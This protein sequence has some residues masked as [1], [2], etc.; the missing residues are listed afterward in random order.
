MT[1]KE[2]LELLK[3]IPDDALLIRYGHS[4]GSGYEDISEVFQTKIV[5]CVERTW[6]GQYDTHFN[7]EVPYI[8][9]YLIW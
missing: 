3:D 2:L 7:C 8:T 1:K 5:K 9:A 4:D 6:E